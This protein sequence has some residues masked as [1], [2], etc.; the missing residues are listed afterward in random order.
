M[1]IEYKGTSLT[2]DGDEIINPLHMH[3]RGN[4]I[5]VVILCVCLS[6]TAL[7]AR[8][9][10]SPACPSMVANYYQ[11][12]RTGF[13]TM[14]FA[15]SALLKTYGVIYL[16]DHLWCTACIPMLFWLIKTNTKTP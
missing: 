16:F 8:V 11:I 4:I 3:K 12:L 2:P 6:V 5:T 10:I 15:K 14:D 7:S 9:L 13:L 1:C